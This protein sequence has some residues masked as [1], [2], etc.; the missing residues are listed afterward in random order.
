MSSTIKLHEIAAEVA[1]HPE[2]EGGQGLLRPGQEAVHHEPDDAEGGPEDGEPGRDREVA[3]RAP[4]AVDPGALPLDQRRADQRGRETH[5]HDDFADRGLPVQIEPNAE[6]QDLPYL[7]N[8]V[9]RE[10]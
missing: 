5:E 3:R 8:Q 1:E 6:H 2:C 10:P 9:K 7:A 4:E